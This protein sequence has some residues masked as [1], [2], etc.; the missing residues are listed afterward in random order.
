ME[1]ITVLIASLV[2][3]FFIWCIIWMVSMKHHLVELRVL[4]AISLKIQIHKE[5][6]KKIDIEEITK[7]VEDSIF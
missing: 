1:I 6:G 7:E 5:E 2:L 4:T 3:F